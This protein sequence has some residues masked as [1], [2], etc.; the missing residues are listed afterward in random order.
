MFSS[1][2]LLYSLFQVKNIKIQ[3]AI[4]F[5]H[6]IIFFLHYLIIV[7]LMG[8]YH[9]SFFFKNLVEIVDSNVIK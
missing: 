8:G 1:K 4:C 6:I 3:K 7:M 2:I 5:L 9:I